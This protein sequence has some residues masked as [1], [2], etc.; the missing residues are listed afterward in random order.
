LVAVG[1]DN[2][3]F[4]INSVDTNEIILYYGS[5][6]INAFYVNDD[7]DLA[8]STLTENNI[9]FTMNYGDSEI[10]AALKAE[11][12]ANTLSNHT[13]W[14]DFGGNGTI[15]TEDLEFAI[16]N[17]GT[18]FTGFGTTADEAEA[19]DAY[20]GGTAVGTRDYDILSDWGIVI[21]NL[22]EG[23]GEDMVTLNIPDEQQ[24]AN[25]I[26]STLETTS[27][28]NW[29]AIE[30]TDVA[31]YSAKNVI[32]IG[33][34]AVNKVARKILG[35]DENTPIYGTDEAWETATDGV[36]QG[37]GILDMVASP[38]T[39]GKYALLVAGYEGTDTEKTANFLTLKYNTLS[40]KS[41]VIVDTVNNVEAT[42]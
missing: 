2:E 42:A 11:S 35:L 4:T 37:E 36:G 28:T 31:S 23:F 6:T 38:Y 8:N 3:G 15:G 40:G 30:D 7:G 16:Q 20:L 17:D 25:V 33:G 32:A 41:K 13:L 1:Q 26:I 19:A 5:G 39:T 29:A 24:I 27:T 14:I 9:V 22:D 21:T 12:G 34:T 18:S 10:D